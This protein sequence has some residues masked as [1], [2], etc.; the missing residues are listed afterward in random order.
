MEIKYLGERGTVWTEGIRAR[1]LQELK[2][3]YLR[4]SATFLVFT[5]RPM[6]GLQQAV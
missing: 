2:Y 5:T 4:V 6:I 1:G 3:C